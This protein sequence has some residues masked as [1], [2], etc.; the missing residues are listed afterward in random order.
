MIIKSNQIK[1]NY[2]FSRKTLMQFWV[3]DVQED[4]HCHTSHSLFYRYEIIA[5]LQAN[6]S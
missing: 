3:S 1:S 6:L 4:F 2:S 5:R